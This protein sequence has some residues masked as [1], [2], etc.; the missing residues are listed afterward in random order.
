MS[1]ITFLLTFFALIRIQKHGLA[2]LL[3]IQN[4]VAVVVVVVDLE[5]AFLGSLAEAH[6]RRVGTATERR[7]T[8]ASGAAQERSWELRCAHDERVGVVHGD[9]TS[10]TYNLLDRVSHAHLMQRAGIVWQLL[11]R[12]A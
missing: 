5:C 4:A 11:Q 8:N 12:E 1:A 10:C 7:L 2:K 9:G 6:L 3:L